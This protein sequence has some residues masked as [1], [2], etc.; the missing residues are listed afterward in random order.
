MIQDKIKKYEEIE[1]IIENYDMK[2][3]SDVTLPKPILKIENKPKNN[4]NTQKRIDHQT[5]KNK[6]NFQKKI[7][8][9]EKTEEKN[10]KIKERRKTYKKLTQKTHR[11][12]PVMKNKIEHLFNKIKDSMSK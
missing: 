4:Q 12:Q 9:E 3:T 1:K 11:G 5:K 6:K 10:K 2:I 8:I 7:S